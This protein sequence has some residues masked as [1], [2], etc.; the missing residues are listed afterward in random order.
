MKNYHFVVKNRED[1][2]YRRI[3]AENEGADVLVIV[4]DFGNS[5]LVVCKTEWLG[6]FD[7]LAG[8]LGGERLGPEWGYGSRRTI[9]QD[10]DWQSEES[11]SGWLSRRI[12]KAEIRGVLAE[13]KAAREHL[14]KRS[15]GFRVIL[16]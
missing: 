13:V 8:K 1:F 10:L 12:A 15:Y 16:P 5:A 2:D 4:P 11:I 3:T 9:D 7:S 14:G 6:R